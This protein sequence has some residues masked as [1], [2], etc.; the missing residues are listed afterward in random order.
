MLLAIN[1]W[2]ALVAQVAV[3]F[4]SDYIPPKWIQVVGAIVGALTPIF[5]LNAGSSYSID[6]IAMVIYGI[7]GNGLYGCNFRYAGESFPTRIRA[8]GIFFAQAAVDAMFVV[9]PLLA[10]V[11][12]AAHHPENLLWII[13]IAQVLAGI[14]MLF[15][16]DIRPGH[17]LEDINGEI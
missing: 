10:G 3:G 1:N 16:K 11:F 9:L 7:F 5:M 15:G 2:V 4:L 14:V 6:V 13:F 8:T 17:K 12:F